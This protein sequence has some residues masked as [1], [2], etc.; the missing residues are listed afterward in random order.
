MSHHITHNH[1]AVVS[2]SMT[3]LPVDAHTPHGIKCLVIEQSQGIAYLREYW[4]T[5]TWTH[6]H[7]LPCF[8]PL[9][10]APYD[11]KDDNK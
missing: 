7:P 3:W 9:A 5:D 2:H 4:P 8:C 6:W 1:A 10:W 11:A